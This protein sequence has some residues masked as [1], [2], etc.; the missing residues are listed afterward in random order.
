VKPVRWQRRDELKAKQRA[1]YEQAL[2]D[3]SL[4]VRKLTPADLE[5]LEAKRGRRVESYAFGDEW[6]VA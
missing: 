6:V 2:A 4:T 5:K 3:G 1:A